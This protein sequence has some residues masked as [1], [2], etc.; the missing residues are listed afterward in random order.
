MSLINQMLRDLEERRQ[1]EG[2]QQMGAES[3]PAVTAVASSRRPLALMACG[4]LLAVV[5]WGGSELLPPQLNKVPAETALT[6]A[7]A[8]PLGQKIVA[9]KA[10]DVATPSAPEPAP[11]A[12]VQP[13]PEP[14]A[15]KLATE[16]KAAAPVSAA[17]ELPTEEKAS[18]SAVV[19]QKPV[20]ATVADEPATAEEIRFRKKIAPPSPQEQAQTLYLQGVALLQ[21]GDVTA[22]ESAL[23]QSLE[24]NPQLLDA[25][26]QLISVLRQ[27][28]RTAEAFSQ[29][30]TGLQLH[31][32]SAVL[33]KGKAHHLVSAGRLDDAIGTLSA[34]PMPMLADDLEYHALLAALLQETG[35]YQQAVQTYRHLLSYR[36]Q[37]SI[38]WLGL[39]VSLDQ[40][41]EAAQAKEAYRKVAEQ[42]GLQ[43]DLADY[44]ASRLQ[45]L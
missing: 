44:V 9:D 45:A 20:P 14:V 34:E 18:E 29:L 36:P 11:A 12:V 23:L 22:A 43:A 37:E 39:A 27:N 7:V 31:P 32:Q 24:L 38:W 2:R 19:R 8:E 17:T 4:V 41:G 21:Q 15:V 6:A 30:E 10:Q 42:P 26:L 35:K 28:G 5:I 33:R 3:T 13:R 25:R 16:E 40:G 1:V